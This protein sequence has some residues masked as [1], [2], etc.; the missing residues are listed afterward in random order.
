MSCFISPHKKD[1][2]CFS[3]IGPGFL[4]SP[5]EIILGPSAAVQK[6]E[7]IPFIAPHRTLKTTFPAHRLADKYLAS[8]T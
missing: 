5:R 8:P 1:P 6:I 4:T 2:T 3:R 7:P